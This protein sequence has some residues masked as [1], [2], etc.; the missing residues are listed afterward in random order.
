MKKV[1]SIAIA[2]LLA[3][4]YQANAQNSFSFTC[5][6]DTVIN[7]CSATCITLKA[8]IPDIHSQSGSYIINSTSSAGGCFTLPVDPGLPGT[9]ANLTVDDTYSGVIN[10]P[11][12][13]PFFGTVYN[14][15]V[16][17]TNG[18]IS[19][20]QTLA[21]Q[22]SH[23]TTTPGDLPNTGYDRALIMG[24]YHDLDPAYTTSPNERIKYDVTGTAPH[25]KW[26]LSFYKVPLF[27]TSCQNLI[28]NT[29]QIVL[30]E[31]LGVVDVII[32]DMQICTGWNNGKAMIGMQ[33]YNRDAAIMAPGRRVSD[34][35]WGTVGMNESWRFT[36]AGGP[37]LFRQVQ[38]FDL[39][40]NLVA[41]GDTLSIGNNIFQVSFPNVCPSLTTSYI[42]RSK[43]QDINNPNS[44]IFGT[45]TVRVV[46]TNAMSVGANVTN[47]A[48]N[49]GNT[50]AFT[51]LPSGGIGPYQYSLNS[52]GTYQTS[53]VFSGL[54]GGTYTVRVLD[55]GNSCTRDTIITV[56]QPT[57]I[58]LTATPVNATCSSIANGTITATGSGGIPGYMYSLDGTN[59]QNSNIFTVPNGSYIVTV[60]DANNC[61]KTV[62]VTVGLTNTITLLSRSD[63]SICNGVS[64]QLTTT[65]NATSFNWTPA[66]SLNNPIIASPIASPSS[67]TSYVVTAT[68]GQCTKTAT[69][70]I[71]VNQAVQ[72]NAGPDVTILSGDS[73]QL[74]ASST[75]A[76]SYLWS[77]TLGLSNTTIL[78]PIASPLVTTLYTLTVKNNI[79]CTASDDVLV[80]VIPYC[81]KVRN[82]FTPNGDGINDVWQIYDH[83]DCLKNVTVHIYNRYGSPVYES[84]NYH[85]DWDGRYKGKPLP[86]ATYYAVIQFVLITGKIVT[87]N[88]DLTILR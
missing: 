24:P 85:N 38:L 4:V 62:S 70:N 78:S 37:T 84:Q 79:G 60:K 3:N 23:W 83:F 65:S 36:P 25:R 7:G 17:S 42:V 81:V 21:G 47:V 54:T 73:K 5:S 39:A 41:N 2:F 30:Y 16:A 71:S 67:T 75:N 10:L 40:G 50:G 57:P 48:C 45:D 77:P 22:F 82:A 74:F 66:A 6:A 35:S 61:T 59:F 32:K 28:E 58:T 69:V 12:A 49:A 86:D 19:F 15:L 27:F 9:S 56:S 46:R 29:H 64:V 1:F 88:S 44:F 63:T 72:V 34:P 26:I 8:K 80:T 11:F 43:Y 76:T 18:Y 13:F 14:N 52:G 31:G 68:L 53:N 20:D 33:N 87:V 55:V 51:V